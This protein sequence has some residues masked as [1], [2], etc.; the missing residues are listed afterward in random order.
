MSFVGQNDEAWIPAHMTFK[1]RQRNYHEVWD[2]Y[3]KARD[4]STLWNIKTLKP[5][6]RRMMG[7][8]VTQALDAAGRMYNLAYVKLAFEDLKLCY[9]N[10]VRLFLM[11]SRASTFFLIS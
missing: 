1:L 4:E 2:L 7:I 3:R 6:Q 8:M 9:P 10:Y 5:E 11:F